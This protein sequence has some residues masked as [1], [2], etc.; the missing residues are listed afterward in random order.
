[1]NVERSASGKW[2]RRETGRA[3]HCW[4]AL[5]PVTPPTHQQHPSPP[6]HTPT[7]THPTYTHAPPSLTIRSA[8]PLILGMSACASAVPI[9]KYSISCVI[10]IFADMPQLKVRGEV[11]GGGAERRGAAGGGEGWG[12]GM[13]MRGERGGEEEGAGLRCGMGV[14]VIRSI[15]SYTQPNPLSQSHH[16]PRSPRPVSIT[17]RKHTHQH[18]INPH[19]PT[20]SLTLLPQARVHDRPPRRCRGH[21]PQRRVDHRCVRHRH[22]RRHRA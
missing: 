6:P 5:T 21:A 14:L 2:G 8:S 20:P 7:P 18:T 9:F 15:C 1:M 22:Q 19:L 4:S 3:V 16:P 11:A 10:S 17:S 13:K 12:E